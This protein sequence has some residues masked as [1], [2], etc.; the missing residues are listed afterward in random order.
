MGKPRRIFRLLLIT[1]LLGQR[2]WAQPS[3]EIRDRAEPAMTGPMA[4]LLVFTNGSGS[5]FAIAHSGGG[6][7]LVNPDDMLPVGDHI[8]LFA[9][10]APGYEFK[11]WQPANVFFFEETT[12]NSQMQPNPEVTSEVVSPTPREIL[13]PVLEFR[14]SRLNIIYDFPGVRT[15]SQ[16]SGWQADFEPLPPGD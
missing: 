16:G 13:S 11:S 8:T 1:L 15:I 4:P 9:I 2:L 12:L 5:I 10:P 6:S 14:L 3:S 7:F